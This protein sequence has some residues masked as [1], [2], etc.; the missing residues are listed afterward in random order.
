MGSTN[1][2]D[3]Q[4]DM[5]PNAIA[6]VGMGCKFPGA[7][8]VEEYWHLL[9]TGR[10]MVSEPP[11]GRFPTQ[12]HKRSTEKSVF[13]GNFLSD[14]SSFDNRFFKRS[15]REAASMDPQQRLL[16]E[17]AYQ[18]LESSGF[19]RPQENEQ[20]LEVGCFVGVCASDYNDNVAS[21]PPNAFSTL[22]TLRAFLTGKISHFFGFSGPS[23]TYD[24]ACSSSAVAIDAACKAILHGDCT[25]AIA[26][27]VSI[28]TS[29]HFYQNL[30]QAT[31]LSPTG[32]TKPFDES[33]DG[34][35][36]GEGVGLVV[37]KRL[38][39]AIEDGD[40]I[41]GTILSTA[42]KQSSNKVPITVPHSGSHASLYRKVLEIAKIGPEEVSYLEAHGSGTP[43][44]DPREIEAIMDVF[45]SPQRQTPIYISS[46]KGNIGHTEGASGVAGLIKTLLMLQRRAVPRQVSFQRINPK[47]KID[48]VQCRIPTNTMP[49]VADTLIACVNNYG[50]AGSIAALLVKEAGT[51]MPP[52]MPIK[53]L[54]KYP[55]FLSAN[56]PQ[57]LADNC[58]KLRQHIAACPS[59]SLADIA[60]NLSEKQNRMLPKALVATVS[61]LSE[62]DE[63]LRITASAPD[64]Q[65]YNAHPEPRRV[66]LTFGGQINRFIGLSKSVYDGSALLRKYLHEC[67]EVVKGFG[68]SGIFPGIFSTAPIDDIVLLQ[69]SQFALHYACAR[70]WIVCGLKVDRIVG[71]SFGQLVALTISGVL[72]LED[73]LRLAYGRAVLMKEKWG[74]ERGSM[75]ALD[76]DRRTTLSL[77]EAV[78]KMNPVSAI[79]IAC[80]NGPRSHVLVGSVS[81]IRSV[82][83]VIKTAMTIKYKVLNVTHGFHSRFCDPIIADLEELAQTL[84]YNTPKIPIELTSHYESVPNAQIIAEHTRT[85]V[86]FESAIKRIE[87]QYGACTWIEAGSN[88]SVT[89]IV[90]RCVSDSG[91]HLFCPVDLTKDDGLSSLAGVTANLWKNGHHVQFWPLHRSNRASYQSFNFPPYQFEK[92]KHWLEFGFEIFESPKVSITPEFVEKSPE[93]VLITFSGFTDTAQHQAIFTIDPRSAEWR[94]LV[95]GHAVLQQPLCPAPLYM[96]LVYQAS[97]K[98]AAAKNIA[99]SLY[100]RLEDLEI[101]SSLGTSTDKV[102]QLVLTQTDQ[103]GHKWAFS[104][105]SQSRDG[106]NRERANT[107]ATGKFEIF[108]KDDKS[109]VVGLSRMARLLKYQGLEEVASQHDGEAV[110][111]SIIYNIFSRVVNYH[112]FY[113]GVRHVAGN[114]GT[115]VAQVSLPESQPSEIQSLVSNPVAIDNFFQVAGLYTNCLSPCPEDEVYVCTQVDS[116]HLSP[117]FNG[118]LLKQW[119]VCA[120]SSRVNDR[121]IQND[122]FVLDPLTEAVVFVAFGARFNKVRISS[123]T[124]VLSRVNQAT[125]SPASPICLPSNKKST[126]PIPPVVIEKYAAIEAQPIATSSVRVLVSNDVPIPNPTDIGLEDEVRKLLSRVTDVPAQSFRGDVTL[127]DLGIDSLMATEVVSEVEQQFHI[128]IPQD[129]LPDLQAFS[130]FCHYITSRCGGQRQS[131]FNQALAPPSAPVPIPLMPALSHEAVQR[132]EW[133]GESEKSQQHNDILSRLA[134]LL[135]SH[136]ECPASDFTRSTNLAERGLDSLLCME[137]MSDVEKEFGVPIDLAQLTM[138][139]NYGELADILLNVVTP[140]FVAVGTP[141]S[142]QVGTPPIA[143]LT[144]AVDSAVTAKLENLFPKMVSSPSYSPD[145]SNAPKVFEAIKHDFNELAA[146]NQFTGFYDKVFEKESQLV[147]AYTVETFADLGVRLDELK[148]GAEIPQLNTLAKH[149]H[150]REALYDVLRDGKLLDY[151]G[152]KYIRSEVPVDTV[153]SKTLLREILRDFPQFAT[154][155]KLLDLCGSTLAKLMTGAKDPISHLFGSKKNRDILESFYGS[156]PSYVTMSQLLTSFLKKALST[157]S[158]GNP[159]GK[160]RIIE[161]GAGTGATTKWVVDGLVK[162]GIP[163]E[164]TFTD[165]SAALVAGGK[166]KF[167]NYN[168]MKYTTI[169]IENEPPVEL[170]GQ[171]DVVLSTNC[172]HATKNLSNSFKNIN[173]LLQ[174]QGFVSVVEF[175][176]RL[177]WF[178]IVFGLLDGWWLFEDGRRYVLTCPEFWDDRMRGSGFEHV[179]WTGGS[180]PESNLVRII[181]GFKQSVGEPHLYCSIPQETA[182]G[183]ETLA[184]KHTDK[185]IPLRADVHYPPRTLAADYKAWNIGLMIHGGGHVMLSRKDVRPRQTQL[186][187][188]HGVLPVS[189]DYRLCPETTIVDGPL[190][191]VSDA[192]AWARNTLPFLKLKN[193][194]VRIDP[195]RVIV[196]GWSTGGTLAMSLGFTS[197]PRGLPP[198]EGILV[199][200]CPTNYEDEFWQKPNMPDHSEAYSQDEFDILESVRH[201]PITAYNPPRELV[202]A[203]GWM[204]PKDARSR[205]VLHMNWRGQTLPVLFNGL[206][207][208]ETV[209][210][211]ERSEFARMEQPPKEN[212]IKASP[213]S[214]IVRGNY[215]SPTYIVFGMKDDLIPW[216]QAQQTA[217]ALKEAGVESGITLVPDQPHLFDMFR[218]PDGKRWEAVLDGYRFLLNRIEKK[219]H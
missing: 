38:S 124:K 145:L 165:I 181:T 30:A 161:I 115:V 40:N 99:S 209:L 215:K 140:G 49:W 20:D 217:D 55:V 169:N 167:S 3:Q 106:I 123:L 176:K 132:V 214:Q 59:L 186:L 177:Y 77:I 80:F 32:P 104:F 63:Q 108:T 154:D 218:D 34:Y 27:G 111:G 60:F 18:A 4:R 180:S 213:Y 10:S 98:V 182:S 129:H 51:L 37:L 160:F 205:L 86:D 15:S 16:L 102:V 127:T 198:P 11:T 196:I 119:K 69:T 188:K 100:A 210:E 88:T 187:L 207:P 92:T 143:V 43:V 82:E 45:H 178:D 202:A 194:S 141:T 23:I 21:H 113:K 151:D 138:D 174:P 28:F 9:E 153:P 57:S 5:P 56:S 135:G 39:K 96:E 7:D 58:E 72:S 12:D 204:T 168:C 190:V 193:S 170:Q 112:D 192:Y 65:I 216:Q 201:A 212:I 8:S 128:S 103:T 144:P 22:G 93:P 79:E 66:V 179:S 137:L 87:K 197:V 191:D 73:G 101:V 157:A 136:L 62:L 74:A 67:D 125:D 61:N 175:T 83:E 53:L 36:R 148:T 24:T 130:S 200:Y 162:L 121:E 163:I 70:S 166:R 78:K 81:E 35:C 95:E 13:F 146:A 139:S 41:L 120:I 44:G 185:N 158:P 64:G 68:Y 118:Q 19:F 1:H 29:P 199:F 189:V 50:A 149:D 134:S 47:I 71:H 152:N 31:F 147:L 84:Q 208:S 150:L 75:V 131:S 122:I 156:S 54:S 203:G 25:S 183:V 6:V 173:K 17:V 76:A 195:S 107:H 110:H 109:A 159:D 46:V 211:T 2:D 33:A 48:T 164:Y 94:I 219:L 184:F 126:A 142:T 89:S 85:S 172:I 117:D 97:R 91:N 52:P 42:V 26:G 114:Q 155:H 90:R 116:V 133:A 206:P 105:E 171:F 14:V